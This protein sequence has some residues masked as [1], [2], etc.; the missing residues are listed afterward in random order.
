M[1]KFISIIS[2]LLVAMMILAMPTV[3]AEETEKF[4][5]PK[6][7]Q[8]YYAND[9]SAKAPSIDGTIEEGEYGK[10]T[11][12]VTDPTPFVDAGGD[13]LENPL[14]HLKSEYMDFYFAYDENEKREILEKIGDAKYTIQRSKGLGENQPDMMNLTTMNPETRRLIKILPEEAEKVSEMFDLLL[15]DNLAGRKDYIQDNGYL[16]LDDAD[17]S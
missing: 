16:Y 5:I 12:R 1:K 7:M 15:G 6:D 9:V 4:E 3:A 13:Y 10:L 14:E 17:I 11:V 2:L 8:I